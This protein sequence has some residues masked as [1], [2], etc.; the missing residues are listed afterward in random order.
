[1]SVVLGS[2]TTF[3]R[4]GSDSDCW[5]TSACSSCISWLPSEVFTTKRTKHTKGAIR[6][7]ELSRSDS[8]VVNS[9]RVLL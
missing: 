8:S 1:M 2:K 6:T 4:R 5:L 7:G 9:F 3:E